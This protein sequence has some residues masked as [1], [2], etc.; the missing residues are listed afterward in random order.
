M[1]RALTI[2]GASALEAFFV[3]STTPGS[4]RKSSRTVKASTARSTLNKHDKT[5]ASF[6]SSSEMATGTSFGKAG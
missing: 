5:S 4:Q 6:Q 1:R 3:S 2:T